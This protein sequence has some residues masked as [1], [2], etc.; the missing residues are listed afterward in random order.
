MS[1]SVDKDHAELQPLLAK[2]VDEFNRQQFFACHETLEELWR[3]YDGADREC[4][5]GIIQVAVAYYHFGRE[6]RRGALK[7]LRCGV[8]RLARFAPIWR[9]FDLV[10]FTSLLSADLASLEHAATDQPV[11]LV[12]P[13][14]ERR[15]N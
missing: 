11:E 13:A 4:I 7:L 14:L 15:S 10:R 6:N 12:I 8:S 1:L 3:N 5:Q 2:G 9:E